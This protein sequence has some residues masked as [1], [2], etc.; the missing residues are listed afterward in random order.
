MHEGILGAVVNVVLLV[1][2]SLATR[3]QPPAHTA[4]FLQPSPPDPA[5]VAG[6]EIHRDSI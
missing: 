3:P 2:V 5:Q 4:A 6:S 1:S